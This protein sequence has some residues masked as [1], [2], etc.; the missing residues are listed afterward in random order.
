MGWPDRRPGL[1]QRAGELL[2]RLFPERQIHMRTQG[3][4]SFVRLSQRAQVAFTATLIAAVGWTAFVSVTYVRHDTVLTAKDNQISNAR[5]AYRSLLGEVS[6]YQMKFTNLAR[7][8]EDNHALMLGLVE[9]NA[10][11]QQS[12]TSVAK[13][14]TMT[15]SEREEIVNARERLKTKLSEIED[16][17]RQMSSK[18]FSLSDNLQSV[19]HDLQSALA[20]RNQALFEGTR[21]NRRVKELEARLTE[22]QETEELAVQRLT[23]STINYIDTMEKV[24]TIAGLDV[25]GLIA[26]EM[27]RAKEQG[28]PFIAAKPDDLPAKKLRTNLVALDTHLGR[29]EALQGVMQKLPLTVPL[30]SYNIT[31]GYGKRRDPINNRWAAHYGIDLGSTF[32]APVYA[33]A[34]GVVTFAGWHG[35]YGKLIEIDHGAG[36]TTR[37]G[38]LDK[39]LVKKGD[40]VEFQK[41]IGQLG[42]T[43]RSTGAHLHYE[44]IYKGRAKN[45]MNFIRAGRYVFQEQ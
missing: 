24:V 44:I 20:E 36:L 42:N 31:S 17:M 1:R 3:R 39:F 14:L 22:L 23:E 8:L 12:L 26:G 15:Q 38:H 37:Y 33:T 43:G 27:G 2:D 9:K 5:A 19:E 32:K 35:N 45:P 40:K 28:G 10:S 4:V 18:N 30:S 29:W 13:Q 16:K 34:P 41:V 25:N 21:M 6:D 11:L 7:D